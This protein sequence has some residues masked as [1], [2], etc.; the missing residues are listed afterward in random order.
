MEAH[1][2]TRNARKGEGARGGT[3]VSFPT[4]WLSDPHFNNLPQ[5]SVGLLVRLIMESANLRTDGKLEKRYITGESTLLWIQA[6]PRWEEDLPPLEAWGILKTRRRSD[7][8]VES[9]RLDWSEQ[10]S[11]LYLETQAKRN[12]RNVKQARERQKKADL[13]QKKQAE[14][15][16]ENFP[17]ISRETSQKPHAISVSVSGYGS[18][19]VG[20]DKDRIGKD[21]DRTKEEDKNLEASSISG[22]PPVGLS[23][24]PLKAWSAPY[25]A[26]ERGGEFEEYANDTGE[27]RFYS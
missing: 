14:K 21:K 17:E 7:G 5:A 23:S 10:A 27:P 2:E 13:E 1:P 16:A 26:F 18:D 25:S 24:A 19:Y 22:A 3:D 11:A 15:L 6:N 12:R 4:A 9:V 8:R 20:K